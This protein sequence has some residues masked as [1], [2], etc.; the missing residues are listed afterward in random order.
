VLALDPGFAAGL[1]SGS[2]TN[3]A[4]MGTATDAINGLAVPEAD[5]A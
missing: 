4:S 2:L 5:R 3:N 1:M